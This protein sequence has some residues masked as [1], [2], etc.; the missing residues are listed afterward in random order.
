MPERALGKLLTVRGKKGVI[1]GVIKKQGNQMLGG[2]QFD[3]SVVMPYRFART[4][5]DE[6]RSNPLILV[7]GQDNVTSVAL[8]D[9]LKG[10]CEL[11]INSARHRK[12][13]FH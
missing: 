7:Q 10:A 13:I 6:R 8:K 3:Q 11:F 12:M 9:D 2:W 5:M 1:I 4:I